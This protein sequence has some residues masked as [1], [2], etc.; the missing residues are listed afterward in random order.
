[1]SNIKVDKYKYMYNFFLYLMQ[2]LLTTLPLLGYNSFWFKH[3]Y[4]LK[5]LK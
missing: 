4:V 2:T 5:A 1:M 3:P